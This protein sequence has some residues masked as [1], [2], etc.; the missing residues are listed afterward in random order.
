MAMSWNDYLLASN[1]YKEK[2]ALEEQV[3]KAE[4]QNQKASNW[5]SIGSTFGKFGLPLL[6]SF[7]APGAAPLLLGA[8]A[9][10]GSFLGS[11][12][13]EKLSGG[14][15]KANS[16]ASKGDF[17]NP[18]RSDI[19]EGLNDFRDEFKTGQYANAATDGLMG[20]LSAGMFNDA[21]D[22]GRDLFGNTDTLAG[23]RNFRG[24]YGQPG[25][26]NYDSWKSFIEKVPSQISSRG[27]I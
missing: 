8:A 26:G 13:G 5:S 17:Y 20:F 18:T 6:A 25:V 10:G 19:R 21:A 11:K 2:T 4:E 7:V 12:A 3:K 1:K 23:L 9:A 16:V 14:T 27:Y 24:S 22:W 15:A